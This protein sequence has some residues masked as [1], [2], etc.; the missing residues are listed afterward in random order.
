MPTLAPRLGVG[1]G[2]AG[3]GLGCAIN[4]VNYS[5]VE[6]QIQRPW[7]NL[8]TCYEDRIYLLYHSN[9]GIINPQVHSTHYSV[10]ATVTQ[11]KLLGSPNFG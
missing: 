9:N 8:K 1:L 10:A 7:P 5:D 3:L 6:V 2:M 4:G 11:T